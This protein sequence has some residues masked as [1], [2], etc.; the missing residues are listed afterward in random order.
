MSTWSLAA[1]PISRGASVGY[2]GRSDG[3]QDLKD[4][5]KMDWDFEQAEDGNIALTGEIDLSHGLEF[6]LA[7]AF[8]RGAQAPRPSFCKPW[9]RLLRGSGEVRQPMATHR[10]EID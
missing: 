4:H 1:R 8:G 3:W 2:A 10:S 6:V 7:V 5:F 9:P